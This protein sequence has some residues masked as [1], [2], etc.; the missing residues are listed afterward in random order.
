MTDLQS[1]L[2]KAWEGQSCSR[3]LK[4][5]CGQR[6]LDTISS[7]KG[8]VYD[9]DMCN[10]LEKSLSCMQFLLH[11]VITDIAVMPT[12]DNSMEQ[13]LA[14]AQLETD[15]HSR[16]RANNVMLPRQCP[17]ALLPMRFPPPRP[18]SP[19]PLPSR[20]PR[21]HC[22]PLCA[23]CSSGSAAVVQRWCRC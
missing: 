14:Y 2:I 19:P 15:S 22:L 21:I 23:W 10:M 20:L 13:P 11:S 5:S 16:D 12:S 3:C 17:T 9:V 6:V 7:C 4:L 1:R 18:P 8:Q